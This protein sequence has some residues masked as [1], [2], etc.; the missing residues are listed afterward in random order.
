MRK[1]NKQLWFSFFL[2]IFFI[3]ITAW[4]FFDF[5]LISILLFFYLP[6]ALKKR[7]Q[8][9]NRQKKWE[10]NLAFKDAMVCLENNLAVGYSPE[11]SLK[12]TVKELEQLYG[13]ETELCLELRQMVKKIELGDTMEQVFLDFGRRSAVEDI[14]QFAEI[15]SV[16]KRTGGNIGE[17]LRQAGSVLQDRIELKRDLHIVVAAK[18]M[19]F[20]VMCIV[21]YGIL[22]YLKLCASSMTESLYHTSFGIFFMG[23]LFIVYVALKMFGERI[24]DGEI[25]KVVGN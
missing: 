13:K 3:V 6:F 25:K 9:N 11:S 19:E 17:V 1:I 16:V 12:E 7:W 20:Q 8:E 15:F 4:L 24:V 10:L 2:E 23:M 18:K 21:P 14:R 5:S 22:L